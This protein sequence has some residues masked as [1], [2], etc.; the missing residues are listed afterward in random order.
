MDILNDEFLLFLQCA[1]QNKLRYMLIGG[2]SVNYYAISYFEAE[3]NKNDFDITPGLFMNL[4]PYNFL[5]EMKIFSR[6]PKD[7]WD[8]SQLEKLRNRQ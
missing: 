5:K 1:Q 3:E 4:V 2:Y 8:I 7:L 6:R